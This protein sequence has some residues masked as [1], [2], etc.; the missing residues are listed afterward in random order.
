MLNKQ[1]VF[2]L[3]LLVLFLPSGLSADQFNADKARAFLISQQSR[4][5]GLVNSFTRTSNERLL[6]QAST[7][8][9]ALAGMAFLVLGDVQRAEYILDFFEKA[10]RGRGFSNFYNTKTGQVGI[11]ATVHLGPNAWVAMLAFQHYHVTGSP[12]YLSLAR[13][14]LEWGMALDRRLGGFAMGPYP[15]WGA[16]WRNVFSSENNLSFYGALGFAERASSKLFP[17]ER[18]QK[19]RGDI[20]EFLKRVA[21]QAD[22]PLVGVGNPVKSSDV[23]SFAVLG[24]NLERLP[25]VA[26]ADVWSLLEDAERKFLVEVDG[27][28]GFEFTTH[29]SVRE[30][31]RFSMVSLEWSAMYVLCYWRAARFAEVQSVLDGDVKKKELAEKF[32][33]KAEDLIAELD[34]KMI[35]LGRKYQAYPYATKGGLQ[36]FPFASWWKTPNDL[37]LGKPATALSSICWRIF[38]DKRFNP[39]Y[40]APSSQMGMQQRKLPEKNI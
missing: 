8:D 5:T 3:F 11:E 24:L 4:T 17:R 9:Q 19:I 26:G 6:G 15:D 29:E 25:M 37:S 23:I 7:Y 20:E 40:D 2:V 13:D 22:R 32:S 36:V 30:I 14:I 34:K 33:R 10:W 35:P 39:F 38:V 28:R 31:P 21:F 12:R 27:M 1:I 18:I 16:N